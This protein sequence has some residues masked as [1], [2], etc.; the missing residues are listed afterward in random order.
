MRG[1][2]IGMGRAGTPLVRVWYNLQLQKTSIVLWFCTP[3]TP[4][5][6]AGV[7]RRRL[8]SYPHLSGAIRSYP[9]NAIF[10]DG[11]QPPNLFV[12]QSPLVAPPG[13]ADGRLR[14][15]T[16]EATVGYGRLR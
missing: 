16:E 4:W 3:G 2:K 9:G 5:R 6:K 11:S 15:V 14:K 8:R 13:S 12:M 1:W 7:R 10:C